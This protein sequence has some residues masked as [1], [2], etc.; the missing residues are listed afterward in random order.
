MP[1]RLPPGVYDSL[2]TQAI[3]QALAPDPR[4]VSRESLDPAAS[5]ERFAR[6]FSEELARVLEELRSREHA[7]EKQ[8]AIVNALLE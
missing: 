1:S 4:S 7:T 2:V 6:H 8:A 3:A 5:H